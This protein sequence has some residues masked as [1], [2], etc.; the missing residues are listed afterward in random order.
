ME[1]L[2]LCL[3][4]KLEDFLKDAHLHAL[5]LTAL[6]PLSGVLVDEIDDLAEV[7]L[8]FISN[9]DLGQGRRHAFLDLL[10]QRYKVLLPLPRRLLCN[11]LHELVPGH[12]FLKFLPASILSTHILYTNLVSL[13][14]HILYLSL[15]S[16]FVQPFPKNRTALLAP[17]VHQA[18][19]VVVLLAIGIQGIYQAR[20]VVVE[21][22]L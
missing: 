7:V 5:E 1:R 16:I 21:C 18:L 4:A 3:S 17:R 11:R 10:L 14:Q 9:G 12:G 13:L 15:F 2:G 19:P 8:A 6:L 22:C 20:G